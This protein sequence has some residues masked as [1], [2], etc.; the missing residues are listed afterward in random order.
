MLLVKESPFIYEDAV[1]LDKFFNRQEE[2]D[3]FV[4]NLSVKRKMLLCIVAPLKYGKSSLMR[5]YL[6]ILKKR[7]D[8]IPVYVNLKEIK[9]PLRY[10]V[11]QLREFGIDLR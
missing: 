8:I 5:K 6:E 9:N 2:I 11:E 7:D 3:F 1:P 4:R 10:I